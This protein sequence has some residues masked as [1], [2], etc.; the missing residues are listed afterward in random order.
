MLL[1]V[2]CMLH[3]A[4]AILTEWCLFL[5]ADLHSLALSVHTFGTKLD[6]VL[7]DPPREVYVWW[8]PGVGQGGSWS[9]HELNKPQ[10]TLPLC[11]MVSSKGSIQGHRANELDIIPQ[12]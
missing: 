6:V 7:V 3:C 4:H 8:A 12:W 1:V 5:Q 9:W 10:V 2:Q 11:P